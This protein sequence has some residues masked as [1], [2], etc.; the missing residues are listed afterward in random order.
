MCICLKEIHEKLKNK[1]I[2][3]LFTLS[4]VYSTSASGVEQT[5]EKNIQTEHN[6][7]KSP[8]WLEANQLVIYKHD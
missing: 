3:P 6:I 8:N 2:R 5:A 1:K 7:V 4:S